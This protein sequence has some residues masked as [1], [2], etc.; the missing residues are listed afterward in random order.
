MTLRPLPA[1]LIVAACA[2][3]T[4]AVDAPVSIPA[5]AP[6]EFTEETLPNG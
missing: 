5:P 3:A 6:V 4:R 1:L 2:S